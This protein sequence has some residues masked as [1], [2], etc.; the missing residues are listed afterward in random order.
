MA[1]DEVHLYVV[2]AMN[3]CCLLVIGNKEPRDLKRYY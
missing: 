2:L 1:S 3:L